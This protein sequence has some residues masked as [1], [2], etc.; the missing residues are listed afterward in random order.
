MNEQTVTIWKW[1]STIVFF[2]GAIML[3]SNIE[4]SKWGFMF[5]AFGHVIYTI[6]FTWL[7]DWPMAIHGAGF[8]VIDLFGI[9]NWFE[10]SLDSLQTYVIMFT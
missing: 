8:L 5:L 4:I 7:K 6:M 2:A 3:S 10:L 9:W 1:I